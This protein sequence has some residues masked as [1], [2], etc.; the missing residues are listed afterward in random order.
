MARGRTV[1]RGALF[2]TVC[3]YNILL[4]NYDWVRYNLYIVV[5]NLSLFGE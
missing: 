4:G 5:I 2:M 3:T 1:I